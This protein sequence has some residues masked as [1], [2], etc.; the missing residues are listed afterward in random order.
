MNKSTISTLGHHESAI[1]GWKFTDQELFTWSKDKTARIWHIGWSDLHGLDYSLTKN[2][3]ILSDKMDILLIYFSSGIKVFD[4]KNN[5]ILLD[6]TIHPVAQK[7][8]DKKKNTKKVAITS[9]SR[10][11]GW[12]SESEFYGWDLKNKS[13]LSQR[14]EYHDNL[15]KNTLGSIIGLENSIIVFRENT[16][17]HFYQ[18]NKGKLT[19]EKLCENIADYHIRNDNIVIGKKNGDVLV[20]NFKAFFKKTVAKTG[21]EISSIIISEDG[22]MA[23]I[24]HENNSVEKWDINTSSLL[25]TYAHKDNKPK[26]INYYFFKTD[27]LLSFRR[28]EQDFFATNLVTGNTIKVD[29]GKRITQVFKDSSCQ[30]VVILHIEDACIYNTVDFNEIKK[31]SHSSRIAGVKFIESANELLTFDLSGE[32]NVWDMD[33]G[34]LKFKFKHNSQVIDVLFDSKNNSLIASCKNG[35]ICFWSEN[36]HKLAETNVSPLSVFPII[37]L[38]NNNSD[39]RVDSK[40]FPIW[41]NVDK[42]YDL[43][44]SIIKNVRPISVADR[45]NDLFESDSCEKM[46]STLGSTSLHYRMLSDNDH[47]QTPSMNIELGILHD[48]SAMIVSDK[49]LPDL[50]NFVEYNSFDNLLTIYFDNNKY[51][52]MTYSIPPDMLSPFKVNKNILIYS[53]FEDHEP[54]GYRAPLFIR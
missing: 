44:T 39:L 41:N 18:N 42:N 33:S 8:K 12:L 47:V 2:A 48:G 27:T 52:L 19:F 5:K 24:V 35:T 17:F 10:L 50:V 20:Y 16:L 49:P 38:T 34:A 7:Y 13:K 29:T 46:R 6:E 54:I 37:E 4:T 31:I 30:R 15:N 25:Y 36:G 28:G 32:L 21:V 43:A 22:G 40:I 1:I 23:I 9:D 26:T 14:F 11:I 3:H 51:L 45:C 53:L